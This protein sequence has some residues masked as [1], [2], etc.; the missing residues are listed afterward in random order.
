MVNKLEV[1]PVR[2]GHDRHTQAS[3][4]ARYINKFSLQ[5][6]TDYEVRVIPR[7]TYT[8]GVYAMMQKMG[9]PGQHRATPYMAIKDWPADDKTT[10]NKTSPSLKDN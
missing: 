6:H 1:I 9:R 4:T 3:A 10:D 8:D 7:G 2:G 5:E